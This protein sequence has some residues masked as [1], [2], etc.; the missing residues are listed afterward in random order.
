GG[1]AGA[2][3]AR[4]AGAEVGDGERVQGGEERLLG[5]AQR[6]AQSAAGAERTGRS[7]RDALAVDDLALALE[8]AHEG[9]DGGRA[10]PFGDGQAAA[11]APAGGEQA[12]V[13]EF[14][15]DLRGVRRSEE[16]TSEL[17]S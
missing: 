5:P 15:D 17:Q 11:P 9:A 10:A 14:G 13:L 1:E 2:L 16:Y 8:G 4:R 7:G 12:H 6:A 3:G